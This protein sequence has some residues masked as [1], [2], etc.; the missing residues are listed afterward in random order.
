MAISV[1]IVMILCASIFVVGGC[2]EKQ[3]RIKNQKIT[4]EDPSKKDNKTASSKRSEEK[5]DKAK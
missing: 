2:A 3:G 4:K 5:K 1:R